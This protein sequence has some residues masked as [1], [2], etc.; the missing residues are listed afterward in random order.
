MHTPRSSARNI[1][2]AVALV[3][4]VFLVAASTLT[5][6]SDCAMDKTGIGD[7]KEWE[8]LGTLSWIAVGAWLLALGCNVFLYQRASGV[9]DTRSIAL[10]L[11]LMPFAVL[12][13]LVLASLI[14]PAIPRGSCVCFSQF[15]GLT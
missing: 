1:A 7:P 9:S 15:L 5:F 2:I 8:R 3:Q 13:F 4:V 14:I 12:A 11:V 6:A 10:A